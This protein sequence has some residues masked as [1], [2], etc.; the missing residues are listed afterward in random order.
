M[1][2]GSYDRGVLTSSAQL[3]DEPQK[4]NQWKGI[5]AWNV[6][7]GSQDVEMISCEL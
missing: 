3:R 7:F 5:Y 1:F 2:N 6:T 4:F